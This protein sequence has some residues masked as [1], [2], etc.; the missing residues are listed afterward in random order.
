MKPVK[1]INRSL[2]IVL[3]CTFVLLGPNQA[4]P[5]GNQQTQGTTTQN[6]Q[7]KVIAPCIAAGIAIGIGVAGIYIIYRMCQHLP[8]PNP[9]PPPPPPVPPTNAPPATN[10]II[11]TSYETWAAFQSLS[12]SQPLSSTNSPNTPYYWVPSIWANA[13]IAI[14]NSWDDAASLYDIGSLGY[15]DTNGPSPAPILYFATGT[16]SNLVSSTDLTTWSNYTFSAWIS[17]NGMVSVLYDGSAIPVITNYGAGNPTGATNFI[18]LGIWVANEPQKF[19]RIL[20]TQ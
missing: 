11:L 18:P 17:T 14:T 5:Q 7:P 15:T 9:P 8:P 2:A 12:T 6:P 16:V 19:F 3:A 20:Q 4:T 10:S 13:N 1:L